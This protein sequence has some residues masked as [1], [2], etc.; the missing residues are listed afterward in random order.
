V[1]H[2]DLATRNVL[3]YEKDHIK[4]SD[5]GL[6]RKLYAYRIY[7]KTKQVIYQIVR[8][9][10]LY[11]LFRPVILFEL[12][13]EPVPWRWLSLETLKDLEFSHESDVWA[14]GV[15][16]WEIFSLG[17]LPYADVDWSPSFVTQLEGGLRLKKPQYST[18]SL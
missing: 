12:F 13:K 2:G 3:L 5:F 10:K 8:L 6:S 16:L 18:H 11:E 1:V 15:T 17:E 14:Y 7:K 4:I 9:Y